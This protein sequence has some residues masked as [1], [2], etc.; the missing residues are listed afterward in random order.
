MSNDEKWEDPLED[1]GLTLGPEESLL[2]EIEKSKSLKVD[3]LRLK[4]DI[5]Q[6]KAQ[7]EDL[8]EKNRQLHERI[9]ELSKQLPSSGTHHE[10][11][12][13][14]KIVPLLI[15]SLALSALIWF[16]RN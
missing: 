5:E 12:N 1:D 15:I 13:T 9:K 10:S 7:K 2:R 8:K 11:P 3:R 4:D 14:I 6:L 16:L